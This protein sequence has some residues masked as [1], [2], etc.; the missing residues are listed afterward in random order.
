MYIRCWGSRGQ[1]PVSGPDFNKYGG[2]T[3]C[4][5]IRSN[6]GD[7]IIIDAGSGIRHLGTRL[8]EE[9]QR[10][11]NLLFTH[12]HLDHILGLPFFG[13]VYDRQTSLTV[14]GCPF[15]ISPSFHEQS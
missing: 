8:L 5:E 9:K 6:S 3:T 11:I 10:K 14:Y 2:D 12:L 15:N 1:I 13:P 7:Y 4:L